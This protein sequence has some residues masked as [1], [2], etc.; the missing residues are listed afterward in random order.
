MSAV[1]TGSDIEAIYELEHILI[2]GHSRDVTLG[3][4]PRGAQLVLGTELE[5]H[6]ADTIIMAN[7]GYFQFKGNPGVYNLAMQEGRSEQVF[8][9]DSAGSLGYAAQPGD[10]SSEIALTTFRGVTLFPRLSRNAGMQTEDVL[11]P[12]KTPLETLAEG[13]DKLLA[14]A[15]FPGTQGSKYLSKAAKL[16]TSLLS[17]IS[18][19][20]DTDTVP[21]ADINIF[22]VASGHLYERM[23]NIMIV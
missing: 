23:L 3:P 5:S 11:E 18:K 1:K 9:I 22:S 4:P 2:E 19:S 7:L 16:G 12:T 8:H 14:Q 6:S 17:G 20:T 10:N 15:G 13:A 21:H